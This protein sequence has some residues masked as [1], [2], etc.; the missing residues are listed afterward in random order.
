MKLRFT[1]DS[2]NDNKNDYVHC[3][4][5][6]LFSADKMYTSMYIM[7]L[8]KPFEVFLH[9]SGGTM[10]DMI[11]TVIGHPIF[12]NILPMGVYR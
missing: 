2:D 12:Q 3:L 11:H 1:F 4:E 10:C 6:K 8:Q 9:I 7:P 5:V